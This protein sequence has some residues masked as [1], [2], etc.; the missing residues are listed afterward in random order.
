[1][2]YGKDYLGV[3]DF[4]LAIARGLVPYAEPFSSYGRFVA[5]GAVTNRIIWPDGIY[6][7]PAP[8]GV[9]MSFVSTSAQDG[10]GGTGIRTLEMHYL[11][12]DLAPQRE[13]ITLNGITPVLSV[14][15][16]V[17]FVQCVHILTAGSGKSAAGVITVSNGGGRVPSR[18]DSG[19][20]M[21]N[22]Q[23]CNR[24]WR[25]VRVVRKCLRKTI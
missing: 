23:S 24:D 3:Q 5:T 13:T 16:N 4:Q 17:R 15:T 18:Y 1:M 10:V 9:Q 25:L 6:N 14:A 8:T 20:G 7:I 21:C 2:G 19:N 12:A 11:D 22:R